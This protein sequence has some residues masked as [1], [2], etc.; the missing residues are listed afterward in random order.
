MKRTYVLDTFGWCKDM[1]AYTAFPDTVE[2][3]P[4][5]GMSNYPYKPEESFP[6]GEAQ[7]KWREK[8]QTRMIPGTRAR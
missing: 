1:D 6:D 7:R 4:F 8:H 5:K 3:L 2:P